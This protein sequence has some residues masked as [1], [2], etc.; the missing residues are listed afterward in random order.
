MSWTCVVISSDTG[1]TRTIITQP[2]SYLKVIRSAVYSFPVG[3]FAS[4]WLQNVSLEG[5]VIYIQRNKWVFKF[6]LQFL[7][8]RHITFFIKSPLKMTGGNLRV[9]DIYGMFYITSDCDWN[10]HKNATEKCYHLV[11]SCLS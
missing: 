10:W 3:L 7:K 1:G 6:I 2:A 11:I 8:C 4:Y 5:T 9:C